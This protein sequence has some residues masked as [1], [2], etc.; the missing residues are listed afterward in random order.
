MSGKTS[1]ISGN[2]LESIMQEVLQGIQAFT[3]EACVYGDASVMEIIAIERPESDPGN[4]ADIIAFP[5]KRD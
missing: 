3:S 1:R 5:G 2:A 4:S